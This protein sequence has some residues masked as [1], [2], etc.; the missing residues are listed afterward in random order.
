MLFI[1]SIPLS[2]T[3]FFY[4]FPLIYVLDF[5]PVLH[6]LIIVSLFPVLHSLIIVSLFATPRETIT[7]ETNSEV[8]ALQSKLLDSAF[9]VLII[10]SC[11]SC[12]NS[13]SES[14]EVL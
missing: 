2:L 3:V 5:F 1:S 11:V 6:S 13:R 7:L 10:H 8:I 14:D 4:N 9:T 12:H